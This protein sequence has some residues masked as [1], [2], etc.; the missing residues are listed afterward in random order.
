M[1]ILRIFGIVA[2]LH[3]FALLLLFANP[4]CSTKPQPPPVSSTEPAAS[5]EAGP[6]ITMPATVPGEGSPIAAAPMESDTA[7]SV[8]GIAFDPNA[9]AA[10]ARYSPTRPGTT[11]AAALQTAEVTEVTPA[12]T[13]TVGRGDS[14]WSIAHKH[15]ISVSDLA[16]ANNLKISASL[17][18]GQ[19]LIVPGKTPSSRS[20]PARGEAATPAAPLVAK[21]SASASGGTTHVVQPGESLG[22]IARRYGVKA[23]EIGAANNIA[24]PKKLRAGQ[25]LTIPVPGAKPAKATPAPVPTPAP[26]PAA[27]PVTPMPTVTIPAPEQDLDAG[28]KPAPGGSVP[29][30]QV[31]DSPIKPASN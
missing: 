24:D 16:A 31:D 10:S 30:I 5:A 2:G 27:A 22:S 14:L 21:G 23:S 28:L 3:A 29:V 7:S 11:A 13:T 18:A 4:G 9:V 20:T 17:R 12:T 25:E 8:P 6:A 19:K 15:G 26:K 1:K